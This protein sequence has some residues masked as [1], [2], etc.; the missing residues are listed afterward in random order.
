VAENSGAV[1]GALMSRMLLPPDARAAGQA[2]RALREVLGETTHQ[3]WIDAAEL[4]V[5][6]VVTNATL[7]AHTAV[8]L[9]IRLEPEQLR[10]EVR[11]FNPVLP[12]QRHYDQHATTGRGMALVAA[13]TSSCGVTRMDDGKIVWFV[14]EAHPRDVSEEDLLAAFDDAQW[15]L[16]EASAR[17]A[18]PEAA[19]GAEPDPPPSA[20]V[21]APHQLRRVRLLGIPPTLWLAARQHHDTLLRELALYLLTHRG[22]PAAPAPAVTASARGTDGRTTTPTEPNPGQPELAHPGST[23]PVEA[24]LSRVDLALA[25]SGRHTVS[26]AV[27]A[28]IEQR[29]RSRSDR[30]VTLPDGHPSPLPQTPA[31]V[32]LELML[33]P[34]LGPALAALQDA[35]DTAEHLAAA[36]RLLAFPGQPEIVAVRDWVTE[37]VQAQLSGVVA[38]PWPGTDQQRFESAPQRHDGLDAISAAVAFV[39]GDPRGLVAADEGN[40]IVAISEVLATALGWQ[41]PDL[42][43]RRVVALIPPALREA[44]VAGFTRHLSTGQAHVLGTPL[45]LPV[46]R[47][48]GTQ[49]DCRFLVEQVPAPAGRSLYL[50]WITPVQ[51]VKPSPGA[52]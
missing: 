38:T 19:S 46:L 22:V 2:R 9:S 18:G 40:R 5:S 39:E 30:I 52:A 1:G 24:D 45:T 13:V 31:T 7:H 25:D 10:V 4:A 48:D 36:G 50:A 43:G 42:L 15:D 20:A 16:D 11:D 27:T 32:D 14:L 3:E 41:V 35:L 51:P 44:H 49:L 34:E 8:E 47:A 33:P 6:E 12:L 29:T 17:R 21:P 23:D 26:N 37:Q 28:T